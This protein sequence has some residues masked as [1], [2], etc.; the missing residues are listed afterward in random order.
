MAKLIIR[1]SF[2]PDQRPYQVQSFLT[3]AEGS[4]EFIYTSSRLNLTYSKSRGQHQIDENTTG[5]NEQF[6]NQISDNECLN[7]LA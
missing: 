1:G 2:V 6:L 7:F 3:M 4:Q 5:I